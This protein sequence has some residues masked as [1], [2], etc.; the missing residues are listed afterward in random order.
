MGTTYSIKVNIKNNY[1]EPGSLN[2]KIDSILMNF[3]SVFSTWNDESEI[4]VFNKNLDT[5]KFLVS[6]DFK[7]VINESILISKKTDGYFDI[8][9]FDLMSFWGF[10]PK[11]YKQKIK[12]N[13]IDSILTFTGYN[14]LKLNGNIL[15][16][17]HPHVKIDLNSIAKGYGVDKIFHYLVDQNY[18][19]IFVEIGGEVRVAGKNPKGLLWKIGLEAPENRI[20][21]KSSFAGIINLDDKSMATSGNY[22]NF[23]NNEG[24]I[25]GHTINPKTGYP[26][27]SNVLSVTVI[28]SSCMESDAWA[29]ALMAMD[30]SKALKI[31][32]EINDIS[33]IWILEEN[34]KRVIRTHGKPVLSSAS[35]ER[36]Y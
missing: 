3:D 16:K 32:E 31:L 20:K 14:L 28:S 8:T 23:I 29:T 33:I 10:G 24:E 13:Q 35:Y 1:I 30:Y 36:L 25:L 6:E 11:P 18:Q 15:N 26:V 7:K 12:L 4:S 9:L 19:D 27:K 5:N 2:I 34:D 21:T 22:R 17:T